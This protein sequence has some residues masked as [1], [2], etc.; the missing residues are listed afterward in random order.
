VGIL[1][2]LKLADTLF[3][4]RQREQEEY[5]L[6][7]QD[8][9]LRR[10]ILQGEEAS[11]TVRDTAVMVDLQEKLR[12]YGRQQAAAALL[13][14]AEGGTPEPGAGTI[15]Q[16]P[17]APSGPAAPPPSPAPAPTASGLRVLAGGPELTGVQR[18]MAS[19]AQKIGLDP[20]LGLAVADHENAFRMVPGDG[21]KSRGYYQV[22]AKAAQDV[23][24]DPATLDDEVVNIH[25]GQAYLK[26]LIEDNGGDVNKA[27]Q[28]YNS[29]RPDGS[30]IYALG[31]LGKVQRYR[32]RLSAGPAD[33]QQDAAPVGRGSGPSTDPASTA[34][35]PVSPAQQGPLVRQP[36]TVAASPELDA[37]NQR[38]GQLDAVEQR[39]TQ[40]LAEKPQLRSDPAITKRLEDLRKNRQE[41]EKQRREL[42]KEET[43][44]FS[45]DFSDYVQ[46]QPPYQ[47]PEQ[48]FA[49]GPEGQARLAE[50]R[51]AHQQEQADLET[52]KE[53]RRLETQRQQKRT[54]SLQENQQEHATLFRDPT[55]G[56]P[57][58]PTV[59]Y[60]EVEQRQKAGTVTKVTSKQQERLETIES[61]LPIVQELAHYV[62][63][64]YGPGG[65]LATIANSPVERAMLATEIGVQQL[66][67]KYPVLAAATR[68]MESNAE[69]L[70]RTLQGLRGAGTEG[71]VARVT[72]GLPQLKATLS[73]SLWPPKLDY[74]MPDTR[75]V[76][77]R[78]MDDLRQVMDKQAGTILGNP[79]FHYPGLPAPLVR[80]EQTPGATGR[81]M[82]D[83]RVRQ[84][85]PALGPTRAAPGEY[86]PAPA[87]RTD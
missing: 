3:R 43:P 81:P 75:G 60:G 23:G 34:S 25:T 59:P 85:H 6:K 57:I 30:P 15:T 66:N 78:V 2:G 39:L 4:A 61:G 22:Q 52:V 12:A 20:A 53:Q 41:L 87:R 70:A 38:L 33:G 10:K 35:A 68:F 76:A 49:G 50:L 84:L 63:Q 36:S 62:E 1:E 47:R 46:T 64:L 54:Q 82:T 86:V 72:Q 79:H 7:K 21:G 18:L 37:I 31:V 83:Q 24:T 65:V 9:D 42:T 44:K 29:G 26:K 17:L 56:R 19:N 67:Q 80:P 14:Q 27:L 8:L 32:Q 71:D 69:G 13:S 45:A 58:D 74:T 40:G 51:T 5:E 55:T 73:I 16:T 77:L 48:L 11:R 28:Q